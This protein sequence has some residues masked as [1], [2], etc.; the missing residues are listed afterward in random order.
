[1]CSILQTVQPLEDVGFN[2]GDPRG[3]S[4]VKA[5]FGI[6]NDVGVS[7]F[8]QASGPRIQALLRLCLIL[9]KR[10]RGPN[11]PRALLLLNG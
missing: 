2:V 3:P 11:I 1:M 10:S 6:Y 5:L 7:I 9:S 4:C 8:S